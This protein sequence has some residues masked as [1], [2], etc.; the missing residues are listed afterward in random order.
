MRL[1]GICAAATGLLAGFITAA[2]AQQSPDAQPG[3]TQLPM[4][5][6]TAPQS[7]GVSVQAT[8]KFELP[9]TLPAI[10]SGVAIIP[11]ADPQGQRPQGQPAA[12]PPATPPFAPLPTTTPLPPADVAT[13]LV[14]PTIPPRQAAQP[15]QLPSPLPSAQSSQLS[16]RPSRLRRRSHLNWGSPQH[17]RQLH[18]HRCNL[19][20]QHRRRRPQ[21]LRLRRRNRRLAPTFRQHRPPY[22][23]HR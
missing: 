4:I 3:T 15:T 16:P 23:H 17:R 11:P 6:S 9:A 21:R 7:A 19:A 22:N 1:A 10:P 12:S 2:D 18:P 13:P 8:P 14:P 20:S 5:F